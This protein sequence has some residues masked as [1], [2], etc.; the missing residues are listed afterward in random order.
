MSRAFL[1]WLDDSVGWSRLSEFVVK[2]C[3]LGQSCGPH[4][5]YRTK[6]RRSRS[7]RLV[8]CT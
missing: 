5:Y 6:F 1:G 3:F 4:M 7:H 2:R 8:A